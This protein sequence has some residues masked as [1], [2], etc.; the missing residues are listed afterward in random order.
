VRYSLLLES[1][2]LKVNILCSKNSF[3]YRL[4]NM[5][6]SWRFA[7]QEFGLFCN[8]C[9]TRTLSHP[10]AAAFPAG[11]VPYYLIDSNAPF[12]VA[13][14]SFYPWASYI[15]S[16]G[17]CAGTFNSAF[18]ALYA[19][20]RL[21]VV[22]SRCRL[23]PEFLVSCFLICLHAVR[24]LVIGTGCLSVSHCRLIPEFLVRQ[25]PGACT[26]Y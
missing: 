11:M 21:M 22:L 25:Q 23:I 8:I 20:S 17:A 2:E 1:E 26:C 4:L 12:S 16:I 14:G 24:L 13:L 15:V 3:L 7:P 9:Q 5:Q 19:M 6:H 18:A 10:T